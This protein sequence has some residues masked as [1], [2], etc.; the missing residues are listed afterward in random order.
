[1][2]GSVVAAEILHRAGYDVWQWQDQAIL[3][4]AQFLYELEWSPNRDD[5][6]T[7]WVLDSRYDTDFADTEAVNPGKNMGWTS[8]THHFAAPGENQPP[9]VAAGPDQVVQVGAFTVLPGSV[10]DDGRPNPPANVTTQWTLQSG[11]VSATATF[12]DS[13]APDSTVAFS[14]PGDY[15]LRLSANDGE[16]VTTDEVTFTVVP[17]GDLMTVSLQDGLNG[18]TG[19]RDTRIRSDLATTNFGTSSKLELDGNPDQVS[20]IRWDTSQIPTE[21]TITSA[22]LTFNV[23]KESNDNY[24]VYEALRAWD[25]LCATFNSASRDQSW[26]VPGAAGPTDHAAEVLASLTAPSTGLVTINLNTEGIAMVRRWVSDPAANHG[27]VIQDLTNETTDDLDFSSREDSGLGPKLTV[28]YTLDNIP[29]VESVVVGDGNP[30]RSGIA[31]VALQFNQATTVWSAASLRVYNHTTGS[32]VNMSNAAFQGN[33]T[34]T[35]TWNLLS[36]GL[37][38]G[39]YTAELPAAEAT[40]AGALPLASTYTFEFSV[41]LGDVN[42]DGAVNFADYGVIG[43][44]FDPLPGTSHRAGDANGD[45]MVNF[46]DYGVIGANFNPA[47]L[48]SLTYDLGDAPEA[49]TNY[50][51]TLANDGAIHVVG[52]GLFLGASIDSESD[53]QPHADALGDDNAGEDGVT[54]GPLTAGSDADITVVAAVPASAVLNAWVDFNADGDW[55]D[56]G[57][58]IFNNESLANGSN[59]L[60]F[61]IPAGA[62]AGDTFARFRVTKSAGYSFTGL[63]ADGEVEDYKLTL[64]AASAPPESSA[65]SLIDPS[66]VE[67]VHSTYEPEAADVEPQSSDELVELYDDLPLEPSP[68]SS[69]A[70]VR[71]ALSEE[72]LESGLWDD[73]GFV[74]TAFEDDLFVDDLT[75]E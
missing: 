70:T 74:D 7:Q 60:S 23:L 31:N 35:V 29:N 1:L 19:T 21:S 55:S 38:D 40:S 17:N 64:A 68:P 4:A 50:P 62:T 39:R 9:I 46:A 67:L 25:E 58:Q 16:F 27:I 57:E 49:S 66:Y 75:S 47:G 69:D 6:W 15:V 34:S 37:P 56:V 59:A 30:N 10:S 44:N 43:S 22:S 52:S 11:P 13:T 71:P 26:E 24:E 20:L 14:G 63:A 72:E 73:P 12:A 32:P 2:Q 36:V 53:G 54:F 18:Y 28:T 33:G 41:L 42:G 48:A 45:G 3:R 8:W 65:S 5:E 61:S 51:T